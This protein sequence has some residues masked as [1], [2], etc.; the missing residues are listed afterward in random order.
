MPME[1]NVHLRTSMSNNY[2]K[3]FKHCINALCMENYNI[4]NGDKYHVL[5]IKIVLK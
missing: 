4:C 5:S 1:S 2:S 3:Y